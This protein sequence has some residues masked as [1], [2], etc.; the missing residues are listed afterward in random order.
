MSNPHP[1]SKSHTPANYTQQS[2]SRSSVALWRRRW[3][4]K[5][6]FPNSNVSQ[7]PVSRQIIII[8]ITIIGHIMIRGFQLQ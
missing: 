8:A 2:L 3:R 4:R 7:S 5:I 6:C 1:V